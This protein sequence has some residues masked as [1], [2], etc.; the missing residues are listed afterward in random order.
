MTDR[1]KLIRSQTLCYTQ[2]DMNRTVKSN[3]LE[4]DGRALSVD[5]SM[6]DRDVLDGEYGR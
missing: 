4:C 6:T 5:D 1:E 3:I 2:C